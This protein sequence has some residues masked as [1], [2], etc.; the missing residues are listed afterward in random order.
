MTDKELKL[1]QT[2]NPEPIYNKVIKFMPNGQIDEFLQE[3][4]PEYRIP[5]NTSTAQLERM[6]KVLGIIKSGVPVPDPKSW[7]EY[8]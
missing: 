5:R 2:L 1:R 4:A 3:H 6:H 7:T 8:I